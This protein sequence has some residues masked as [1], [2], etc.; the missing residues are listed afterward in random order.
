MSPTQSFMEARTSLNCVLFPENTKATLSGTHK[1]CLHPRSARVNLRSPEDAAGEQVSL[2]PTRATTAA[3]ASR[4]RLHLHPHLR[5]GW[6][7]PT[8]GTC[9]AWAQVTPAAKR[10]QV[11]T[12][13]PSIFPVAREAPGDSA[14]AAG[15]TSAGSRPHPRRVTSDPG[16]HHTLRGTRQRRGAPKRSPRI[17]PERSSAPRTPG[18]GFVQ[19]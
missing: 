6:S 19:T 16:P 5:L 12:L 8:G 11:R 9:C 18:S 17:R 15:T 3:P 1:T 7:S 14:A 10:T 4:L 13:G 2:A